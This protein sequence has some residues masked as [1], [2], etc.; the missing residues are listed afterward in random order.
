MHR[1]DLII[2]DCDGVLVDSEPISHEVFLALLDSLGFPIPTHEGFALFRGYS[3]KHCKAT[4]EKRFG[5]S[6]PDDLETLFYDRLFEEFRKRLTPIQ[7][8]DA[9]LARLTTIPYCVASSGEYAKMRVTLG[10]TGLLSRFENRMFSAQ[11][12]ARGKPFP[13]LFLH[14]ARSC[15]VEATHSSLHNVAVIEDSLPGIKAGIAAGMKVFAFRQEDDG[16]TI[17][18]LSHPDITVFSRMKDLPEMLGV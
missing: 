18:E 5:R 13:D 11:D 12:V 9:V 1:W 2:F 15:G 6:L 16:Y 8:I 10:V 3:L 14:A 7:D 17:P 4:V